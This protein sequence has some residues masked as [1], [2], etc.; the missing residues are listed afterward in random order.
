[1]HA[2]VWVVG[3]GSLEHGVAVSV[4]S[5]PIPVLT[6]TDTWTA[7]YACDRRSIERGLCTRLL[8]C[9]AR[10][11]DAVQVSVQVNASVRQFRPA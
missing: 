2:F 5:C 7:C 6:C 9:L 4:G 8:L 10:A 3:T 1:M 11:W